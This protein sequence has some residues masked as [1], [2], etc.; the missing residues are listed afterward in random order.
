VD[1]AMKNIILIISILLCSIGSWAELPKSKS[2][3]QKPSC[4]IY[5]Q[6]LKFA[7]LVALSSLCDKDENSSYGISLDALFLKNQ[8]KC[9]FSREQIDPTDEQVM[10]AY[11][12]LLALPI[13]QQK[14]RCRTADKQI[15]AYF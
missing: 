14:I 1:K 8:K 6:Q 4:K 3:E 9:K 7:E 2:F 11:D 13:E 15:K 12:E 10:N 5:D